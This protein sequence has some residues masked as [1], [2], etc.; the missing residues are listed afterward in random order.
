MGITESINKNITDKKYSSFSYFFIQVSF[1]MAFFAGPFFLWGIKTITPIL[2]LYIILIAVCLFLGNIF[3]IKAY[4]TDDISNLNILSKSSLI[5]AF[6]CGIISLKEKATTFDF[7]GIILII[8]GILLIF[9]E[10]KKWSLSSG[11]ILGL[12]SGIL[13]VLA[14]FLRKLSLEFLNPVAVV[15]YMQI[16]IFIMLL[17]VPKTFRDL[18]PILAKYKKKILFS[19]L[20]AVAGIY[21]F[22]WTLSKGNI[23]IVNTNYETSFLLSTSLIG[24]L[25]LNEKKY[26]TKKISGSTLCILGIILL[27]FF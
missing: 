11:L 1:N 15:Y 17:F 23:S 22:I 3:I 19:R 13:G 2:F 16:I 26:L 14:T 4:K 27:N 25:L 6:F 9:Y 12:I 18:Q 24:I 8:L 20:T 5:V 10:G 7:L 21:L